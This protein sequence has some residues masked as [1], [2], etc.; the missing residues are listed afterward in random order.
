M[1]L[2]SGQLVECPPRLQLTALQN[3]ATTSL[4]G[5]KETPTMHKETQAFSIDRTKIRFV[6]NYGIQHRL[7]PTTP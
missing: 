6:P 2:K 7:C 5:N 4:K 3:T 1:A